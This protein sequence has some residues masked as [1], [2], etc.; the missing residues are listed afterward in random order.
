MGCCT[1]HIYLIIFILKIFLGHW[2]NCKTS[3][4]KSGDIAAMF[5]AIQASSTEDDVME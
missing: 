1:L 5:A 2:K 4:I 3:T